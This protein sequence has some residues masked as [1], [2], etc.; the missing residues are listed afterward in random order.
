MTKNPKT[1]DSEQ[2]R[3]TQI[4]ELLFGD[5][6]RQTQE[7]LDQIKHDLKEKIEKLNEQFVQFETNQNL[8]KKEADVMLIKLSEQLTQNTQ[9][10]EQQK[11]NQLQL[12][13][14][15]EQLITQLRQ[16]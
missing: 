6:N 3:L 16:P 1:I 14:V 5:E 15:L 13:D 7:T 2:A 11:A 8:Q 12:A 4:K 10:I 9:L